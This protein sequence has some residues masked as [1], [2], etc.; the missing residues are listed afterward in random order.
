MIVRGRVIVAIAT[1]VISACEP[2]ARGDAVV[3]LRFW[4]L[5]QEGE[6]VQAMM[7]AFERLHPNIRVH[8]EQI[9]FTAAHEK[10]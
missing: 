1:T 4:A 3:T 2:A 7:P 9:P 10:I 6:V 8:V 5:G